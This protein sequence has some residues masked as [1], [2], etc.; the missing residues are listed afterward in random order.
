MLDIE[1]A[2]ASD[3]GR[4]R[5]HNEDYIG[6]AVP[7]RGSPARGPGWLFALADGVGGQ[8]QGEVA[9]RL[10][11]ETLLSGFRAA[12]DDEPYAALLPRLVQQ[13][14]SKVFETGMATGGPYGPGG[15]AMATTVVAC[16]L[17]YDRV[18]VS[19]VGDSRCYRIRRGQAEAL[20]RDHTVAGEHI[21]LGLITAGEYG[22]A[23]TRHVLSRSLG[24]GMFVGAE[25]HEHQLLPGDLLLLCSDGLHGA[26]EGGDLAGEAAGDVGGQI[27]AAIADM[28]GRRDSLDDAVRG[29][30][31]LA[32]QRDGSDNVSVQLIRIRG[33]ERVGMYRGRPYKLA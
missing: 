30:V 10:A 33:V 12:A 3:C 31:D 23:E 27:A 14:N 24:A 17:R 32:N 22:Q 21:R 4:V 7:S 11:V 20:T 5:G 9:S 19:H 15:A 2:Q 29:L 13:A 26:L 16:A 25:T 18:V 8:A 6:Y 28:L 1:F